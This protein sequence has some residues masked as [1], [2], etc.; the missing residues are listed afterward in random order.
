MEKLT[1]F[2]AGFSSW[3]K[4]FAE[5]PEAAKYVEVPVKSKN[6]PTVLVDEIRATIEAKKG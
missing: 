1:V 6:L 5:W 2:L 4:L 3:E